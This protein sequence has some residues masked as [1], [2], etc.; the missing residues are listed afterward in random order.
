MNN[1]MNDL[2][3]MVANQDERFWKDE[4]DTSL[5]ELEMVK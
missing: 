1:C 4:T 3:Q 5:T 2:L